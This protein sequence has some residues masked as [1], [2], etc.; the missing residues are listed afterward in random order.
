MITPKP[1]F[2]PSAK[3]RLYFANAHQVQHWAT[4]LACTDLELRRAACHVG[5]YP[6]AIAAYL[7]ASRQAS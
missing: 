1:L 5:P 7:R 4:Q 3:S 6:E 2:D